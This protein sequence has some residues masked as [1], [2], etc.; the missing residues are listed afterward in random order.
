MF[1][2][3]DVLQQHNIYCPL[4][5]SK[6]KK[7]KVFTLMI[8]GLR[9][10][11]QMHVI[12]ANLDIHTSWIKDIWKNAKASKDSNSITSK[13]ARKKLTIT[14]ADVRRALDI[15]DDEDHFFKKMKKK[16]LQEFVD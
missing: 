14:E 9:E 10:T 3:D 15:K 13:A 5:L 1:L 6:K 8:K 4:D 2:F 12:T 16:E 7:H 11:P